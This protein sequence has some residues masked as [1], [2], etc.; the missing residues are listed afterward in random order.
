[1]VLGVVGSIAL[2]CGG[3]DV[4]TVRDREAAKWHSNQGIELLEQGRYNEAIEEL[5]KA[6]ESDPTYAKSYFNRGFIYD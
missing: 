4:D 3:D 6:T 5:T 2:G 1:M